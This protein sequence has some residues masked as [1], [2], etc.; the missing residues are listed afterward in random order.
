MITLTREEQVLLKDRLPQTITYVERYDPK[1]VEAVVLLRSLLARIETD[2]A[3]TALPASKKL[4]RDEEDPD[5]L[6]A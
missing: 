3:L 1:S 4:N 6:W 5:Q 2:I